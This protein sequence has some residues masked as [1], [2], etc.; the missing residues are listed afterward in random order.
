[1]VYIHQ[2]S[3]TCGMRLKI[4]F[5]VEYIWEFSFPSPILVA[6]AKEIS[7]PYYL[8]KAI[9]NGNSNKDIDGYK[10]LN[11]QRISERIIS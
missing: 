1:M 2:N 3:V 11:P 9:S 6:K 8:P 4:Y 5:Q 7:L 10:D